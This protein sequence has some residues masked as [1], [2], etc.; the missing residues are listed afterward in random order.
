MAHNRQWEGRGGGGLL[1]DYS[2]L[3]MASNHF[4]ALDNLGQDLILWG[5]GGGGGGD[6][7]GIS[8]SLSLPP[9]PPS[10]WQ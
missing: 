6:G 10:D 9:P 4:S 3:Y 2:S 5:G 7:G 1:K 8:L